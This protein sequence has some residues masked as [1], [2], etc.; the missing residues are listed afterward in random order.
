MFQPRLPTLSHLRLHPHSNLPPPPHLPLRRIQQRNP[1]PQHDFIV[2]GRVAEHQ[3]QHTLFLEIRLVNAGEGVRDDGY[4]V[5]RML[6]DPVT[7]PSAEE[8]MR[9]G[10]KL[11]ASMLSS[12]H[13]AYGFNN[14][15]PTIVKGFGLG[16]RT[17]TLICTA[18]P[19]LVGTLGSFAVAFSPDRNKEHG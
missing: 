17:T 18:P 12:N 8:G 2:V 7:A 5:D 11:A 9:H 13:S 6:P 4:A 16:S 19:Y 15:Y 3:R 1:I 14:F 10:L